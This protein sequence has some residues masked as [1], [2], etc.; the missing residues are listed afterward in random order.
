MPD[1]S[2]SDF[3]LTSCGLNSYLLMHEKNPIGSADLARTSGVRHSTHDG[4]Q[5]RTIMDGRGADRLRGPLRYNE[6]SIP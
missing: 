5:Q 2:P 4:G 6:L 1:G 3:D